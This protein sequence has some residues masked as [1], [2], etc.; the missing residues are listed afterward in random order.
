MWC[1]GIDSDIQTST[2]KIDLQII[3]VEKSSHYEYTDCKNYDNDLF[4]WFDR[5]C[6][7]HSRSQ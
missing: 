5:I 1:I 6:W 2:N 4:K 7:A 3:K